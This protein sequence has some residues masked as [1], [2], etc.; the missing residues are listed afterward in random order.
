[1]TDLI[2]RNFA[3]GENKAKRLAAGSQTIWTQIYKT[4][5]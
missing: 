2:N 4:T 5:Y 1:M 3:P